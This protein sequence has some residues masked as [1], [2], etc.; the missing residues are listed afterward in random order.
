MLFYNVKRKMTKEHL[1]FFVVEK[2]Y[3]VV[4]A[5]VGSSGMYSKM[6]PG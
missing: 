6:S 5:L 2:N 1:P 3:F 4:S